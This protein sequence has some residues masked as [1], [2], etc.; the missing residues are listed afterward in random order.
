MFVDE[1]EFIVK[2]GD[3]GN[4][5]VSFLR[6]KFI[7]KGGPDGGDGG[8]GGDVILKVD[9]GLNTLSDFR[10]QH[11]FEAEDGGNGSGKNQHGK[12]GEDAV[13]SVPPGTIVY[14]NDTNK[15]LADLTE[16]N[17][18]CVIAEGSQGGRGNSRFKK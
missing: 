12:D 7:D 17:D 10:Y 14:D 5:A 4:G 3:G 1:V 8:D 9:E 13:L 6:E 2:G 15:L 18:S 11:Q 16:A